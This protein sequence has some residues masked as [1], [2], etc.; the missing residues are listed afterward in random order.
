MRISPI[1][2][3]QNPSGSQIIPDSKSVHPELQKPITQ[4]KTFVALTV[5]GDYLPATDSV[6]INVISSGD[7]IS[8]TAEY[9]SEHRYWKASLPDHTYDRNIRVTQV[10]IDS[11]VSD[12]VTW[13]G[14]RVDHT[15]GSE[16]PV[17]IQVQALD[18]WTNVSPSH[19]L[20]GEYTFRPM[21]SGSILPSG[22]EK[23]VIYFRLKPGCQ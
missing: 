3:D 10:I 12:S 23:R 17:N 15:Y 11:G 16:K 18:K 14:W 22:E 13:P 21:P 5:G 7:E 8:Q 19:S 2:G 9:D 4:S 6:T 1:L 20:P